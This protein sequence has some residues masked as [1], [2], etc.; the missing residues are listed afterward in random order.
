MSHVEDIVRCEKDHVY[1]IR[2]HPYHCP[3]CGSVHFL[4]V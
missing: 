2:C 3:V 4:K 1:C